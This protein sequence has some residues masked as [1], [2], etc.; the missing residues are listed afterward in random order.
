MFIV[1]FEAVAPI[2]I[3]PDVRLLPMS[4]GVVAR[5]PLMAVPVKT[6]PLTA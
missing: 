5:V 2:E 4:N 6:P 3:E 1:L